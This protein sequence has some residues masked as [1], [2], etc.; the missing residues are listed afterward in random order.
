MEKFNFLPSY[1]DN[2]DFRCLNIDNNYVG[3][4]TIKNYPKVSGFLEVLENLP[5]N[6]CYDYSIHIKKQNTV[7]LLKE[8]TY[9]ISSNLTEMQDTKKIN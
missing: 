9:S 5:K 2:R 3:F 4:L 1:V 8:L 7:K 6:I